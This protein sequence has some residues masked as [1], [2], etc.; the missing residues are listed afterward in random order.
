MSYAAARNGLANHRKQQ[1]AAMLGEVGGTW[2][3]SQWESI[4]AMLGALESGSEN[5][6]IASKYASAPCAARVGD[7]IRLDYICALR[8][9]VRKQYVSENDDVCTDVTPLRHGVMSVHGA[10]IFD[11]LMDTIV[12][13]AEEQ[14]KGGK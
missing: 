8:R 3:T 2:F 14:A 9:E 4:A 10:A 12:R 1:I 11:E 7:H 5:A 6:A 13:H